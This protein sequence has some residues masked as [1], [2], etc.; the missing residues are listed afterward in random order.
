MPVVLS[1]IPETRVPSSALE[2]RHQLKG[3]LQG[4][5]FR[6]GVFLMILALPSKTT[7]RSNRRH[8][9]FYLAFQVI[10][11]CLQVTLFQ[12]QCHDPIFEATNR[13][14]PIELILI[15][16]RA[17]RILLV[18]LLLEFPMNECSN[19]VREHRGIKILSN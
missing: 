15:G 18:Y 9:A 4:A 8:V 13:K 6:H 14:I 10:I 7:S 16:P 2:L 1:H 3:V 17:T 12:H 5:F 19:I 11:E